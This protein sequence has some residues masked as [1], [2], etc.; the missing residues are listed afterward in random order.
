MH[1]FFP[2]IQSA[3][4]P[5]HSQHHPR[6]YRF[7]PPPVSLCYTKADRVLTPVANRY[8]VYKVFIQSMSKA[9]AFGKKN[10]LIHRKLCTC[11]AS[12]LA[13]LA[14]CASLPSPVHLDFFDHSPVTRDHVPMPRPLGPASGSRAEIS[15]TL[16]DQIVAGQTTCR[17]VLLLLGEPDG[18]AGE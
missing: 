3:V 9:H 11:C 13:S 15:K 2:R 10:S 17:E 16:P 18:P 7:A 6:T 8:A 1:D 12:C 5:E 14:G 4:A